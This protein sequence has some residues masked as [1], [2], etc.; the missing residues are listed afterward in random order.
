MTDWRDA[1]FTGK[2]KTPVR[3]S[4]K[5]PAPPPA[6]ADQ[7][8]AATVL[9]RSCEKSCQVTSEQ[10]KADMKAA[11]EKKRCSSKETTSRPGAGKTAAAAAPEVNV[12]TADGARAACAEGVEPAASRR[13]P[14]PRGESAAAAATSDGTED[15]C[16]ARSAGKRAREEGDA[17]LDTG[18]PVQP[19]AGEQNSGASSEPPTQQRCNYFVPRRPLTRS[20]TR[21]SSVSLLPETGRNSTHVFPQ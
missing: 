21:L 16:K 10:I 13:P 3:R 20:C 12:R 6:S 8:A 7:S 5:L 15:S 1:A 9:E 4:N 2:G 17:G 18:R 11:A 14:T 19:G